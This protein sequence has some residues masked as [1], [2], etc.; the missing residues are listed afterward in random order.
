MGFDSAS[1]EVKSELNK[2]VLSEYYSFYERRIINY[3]KYIDLAGKQKTAFIFPVSKMDIGE[4]VLPEEAE[5]FPRYSDLFTITGSGK[6]YITIQRIDQ[7]ANKEKLRQI[8]QQI[9][10]QGITEITIDLRDNPGGNIDNAANFFSFFAHRPYKMYEYLEIRH[11]GSYKSIKDSLNLFDDNFSKGFEKS[12]ESN[13]WRLYNDKIYEAEKDLA[14]DGKITVLVNAAT[15]SA[16][17]RLAEL[18]KEAGAELKGSETSG[19]A[20]FSNG[21]TFTQLLLPNS[22]LILKMPLYRVVY[23]NDNLTSEGLRP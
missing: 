14:F 1:P 23:K 20:N 5:D 13:S 9:K 8:F 7:L 17:V 2:Y 22:N 15:S 3:V 4:I 16:A 12:D 6:A 21:I 19:G 11:A 10:E 18:L